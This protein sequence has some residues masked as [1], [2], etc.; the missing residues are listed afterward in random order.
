MPDP[1]RGTKPLAYERGATIAGG[2]QI[3]ISRKDLLRRMKDIPT[4]RVHKESYD[5]KFVPMQ[6][7]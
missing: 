3:V 4:E 6:R 5:P 1:L 7:G 2:T